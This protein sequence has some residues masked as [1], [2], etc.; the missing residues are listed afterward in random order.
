[1]ATPVTERNAI[2]SAMLTRVGFQAPTSR[3]IMSAPAAQRQM[4]PTRAI[5]VLVVL[6]GV[7][8]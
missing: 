1:M 3:R 2:G 7:G 8:V 5:S 6:F 4:S